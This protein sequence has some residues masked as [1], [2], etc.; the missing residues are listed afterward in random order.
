MQIPSQ[1][2]LP[3]QQGNVYSVLGTGQAIVSA[4]GVGGGRCTLNGWDVSPSGVCQEA[5]A[6]GGGIYS[7]TEDGKLELWGE[8]SWQG[9]QPEQRPRGMVE[10][11][12]YYQRSKMKPLSWP[13]LPEEPSEDLSC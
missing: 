7:G 12:E 2:L 6:G 10:N 11:N 3:S 8:H 1:R 9:F 5:C 4:L 13:P